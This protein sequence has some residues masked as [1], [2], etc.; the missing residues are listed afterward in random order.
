MDELKG[1]VAVITGAASGIGRAVALRV[2][3]EGMKVV[4]ADIEEGALK[5]A[6]GEVGRRGAETTSV[7][8]DV[9]DGASVRELRDRA[10][11]AFGA[12]HL[13]HNNAGVGGGGPIWEVPE[14]DWRWILG[15]NLWGVVH[16]VATFVPLFIEQGE[17]HVVNT[18]SIA[19]LTTAPFLGPYNA[20]KQAVV[21]ISETLFKDL[22]ATG[23]SGV[24]VSVLCPGF[25]RTRIGESARNRPAWA[26]EGATE[27]P[28][29]TESMR[30]AIN[31]MIASGIPPEDVADKV[32][33]AVRTNT[34]YIRT[35][36]E[37]DAAI[38]TRFA[39]ILETRP[40]TI[41]VIG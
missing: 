29:A 16:G 33:A 9:S 30:A 15:V 8:V 6:E 41:T 17:G 23:V 2:A 10:L 7:V 1:K 37:L 27:D 3:D 28:E 13:V 5:E 25:V 34:F 24:G 40:P 26:P 11:D 32:V 31:E 39:E 18:A 35:H 22:Q 38:A 36:P 21:A 12:V 20:T 4:L 19:G 14:Q